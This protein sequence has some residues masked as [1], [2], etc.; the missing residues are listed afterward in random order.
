LQGVFSITANRIGIEERGGD[1]FRFTGKSQIVN[2]K[3]KILAS[4]SSDRVAAKV[5]QIDVLEARD[6]KITK[7]N[8]VIRDR[9]TEF[10]RHIV[11]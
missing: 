1:R 10:Y 8:D 4:A 6:K 11:E 5:V 3:M 2:P 9:R 7:Y